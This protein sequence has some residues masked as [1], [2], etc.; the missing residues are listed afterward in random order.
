MASAVGSRDISLF[1]LHSIS[2]GFTGECG[3]RGGYMEIRNMPIMKDL[4][5]NL[6]EL[7]LKQASVSLCSNT[8]GQAI[9]YDG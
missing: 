1:S 3:H 9:M 5:V 8:V 7:L 2:K 6:S 4:N